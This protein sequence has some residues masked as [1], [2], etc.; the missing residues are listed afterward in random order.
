MFFKKKNEVKIPQHIAFICDGNRRW[1]RRRGMPSVTGYKKGAEIVDKTAEFFIGRGVSTLS[2]FLFST[3]NWQR[4]AEEVKY[5]MK[6]LAE[7]LQ[8]HADTAH[9]KN[10]RVKIIG[11]RDRFSAKVVRMFERIEKQTAENTAGTI[12]MALDY[13]GQDEIVRAAQNAIDYSTSAND[14]R[15]TANDF[16]TFMDTGEL[17]PIDLV[18]RT[19]D[20]QRI[21]NFMLWKMAYAE[22]MF[23]PKFWP[24]LRNKDFEKMLDEY[25]DRKRRFG[26]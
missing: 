12:V 19:S 25:S 4:P 15:L 26:K 1:A 17:L 14:Y 24:A 22:L 8:Q 9:R 23:Y 3:E 5:L 2:Y 18:V 10:I 20:E 13:G 16:E 21:S 11:R 7:E 6:L